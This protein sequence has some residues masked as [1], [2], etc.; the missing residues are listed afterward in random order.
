MTVTEI[1]ERIR[2]GVVFS[3][4]V[5]SPKWFVWN[6]RRIEI[7][8]VSYTWRSAE[9]ADIRLHFSVVSGATCYEIAFNQR[10]LE[11]RLVRSAVE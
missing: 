10:S 2:A 8:R 3:G 1:N 6:R 11:W 5:V 9:G 4:A 7:N